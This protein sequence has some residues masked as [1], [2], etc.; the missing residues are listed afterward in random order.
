MS[1]SVLAV[2][3]MKFL[4]DVTDGH[5]LA[6]KVVVAT[7][8]FALAGLQV[9]M[10]ARFWGVL[11]VSFLSGSTAVKVHRASGWTALVLGVLVGFSC[12]VGPAGP[13]SPTRVLLHS[14]F[15]AALFAALAVKFSVLK[16]VIGKDRLL[17]FLGSAVFLLFFAIWLTSV[18]DYVSS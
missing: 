16:L 8:V 9:A 3:V 14:V 18:F 12:L 6:W 10:A 2:D 1:A 5:L 11:N 15:G 13:T 7:I 4:N 17:P